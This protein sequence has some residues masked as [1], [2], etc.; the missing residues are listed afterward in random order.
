MRGSHRSSEC[1]GGRRKNWDYNQEKRFRR[2]KSQDKT[3]YKRTSDR[4]GTPGKSLRVQIEGDTRRSSSPN[5]SPED[6]YHRSHSNPPRNDRR[7]IDIHGNS[8][9]SCNRVRREQTTSPHRTNLFGDHASLFDSIRISPQQTNKRSTPWAGQ[10][11]PRRCNRVRTIE[12]SNPE[13]QKDKNPTFPVV[14]MPRHLPA[15][16]QSYRAYQQH[17]RVI[18]M[19]DTEPGV[20][21]SRPR[22]NSGPT[23][24]SRN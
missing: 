13:E 7:D 6:K 12:T 24:S 17:K 20:E 19:N 23:Q 9:P 2:S 14:L 11:P 3:S 18:R 10:Q 5:T 8:G 21:H 16:L 15:H 22:S 1:R 4:Q